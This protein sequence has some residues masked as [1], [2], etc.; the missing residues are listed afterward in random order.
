MLRKYLP[1]DCTTVL[2][3]SCS[4]NWAHCTK[5]IVLLLSSTPSLFTCSLLCISCLTDRTPDKYNISPIFLAPGRPIPVMLV[6]NYWINNK[7]NF[8]AEI[9]ISN[10]FN[11]L[12]SIM[13][14]CWQQSSISMEFTF[15][16][17]IYA[18]F[19]KIWFR[20][21]ILR[22]EFYAVFVWDAQAKIRM[23]F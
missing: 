21:K 2:V 16:R 12:Q 19:F 8:D 10:V 23:C 20:Q 13:I 6:R 3:K 11:L 7:V 18:S 5:A 17:L 1:M 15:F 4:I 14:I 9:Y 22:H